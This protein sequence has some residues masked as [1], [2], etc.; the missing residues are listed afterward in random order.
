[1]VNFQNEFERQSGGR[2]SGASSSAC[3]LFAQKFYIGRRCY[4]RHCYIFTRR[5]IATLHS[6]LVHS[7]CVAKTEQIL[8][9]SDIMEESVEEEEESDEDSEEENPAERDFSENELVLQLLH[10]L[11]ISLEV[12]KIENVKIAL[13]ELVS[14][15][16]F[17][18][19]QESAPHPMQRLFY[20]VF[21]LRFNF[22]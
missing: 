18:K 10:L 7:L 1:M 3:L 16:R 12:Q 9:R 15:S 13:R 8:V 2:S 4:G 11:R 6:T 21:K 20:S 17:V 14:Q 5:L 19:M 22:S